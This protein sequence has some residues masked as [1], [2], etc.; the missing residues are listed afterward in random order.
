M[1][2]QEP[3]SGR[4]RLQQR[5]RRGGMSEV[6]LA[7]DEL[8]QCEVAIKLASS[9]DHDC[10]ERLQREAQMMAALTH[11]H[12][13]PAL[14]YGEYNSYYYL[15]MPYMKRGNLRERLAKGSL[16]QQEASKILTQVAS[17]LQFAHDKGIVHRDIKPSNIL[18]DD[19]DE[20]RVYLSDFGLAKK[21]GEGSD[22]TQ[23]GCLI[24]TPEYLAPELAER[25]ESV[26]SD[27]YA[28]GV[29]L[30]QMLTGRVPFTG[31]TPLSVYWKHLRERPELP[32]S[33]NPAVHKSVE[34]VILCALN[35]DPGERFA[36]AKAMVQ[37]YTMALKASEDTGKLLATQPFAPAPVTLHTVGSDILPPAVQRLIPWWQRPRHALQRGILSLTTILLLT[38]PLS[39]GFLIS[40]NSSQ[41]SLIASAST[42]FADKAL[43]GRTTTT[44]GPQNSLTI[45][46]TTAKTA[47]W[48]LDSDNKRGGHQYWSE[49]NHKHRHRC[50]QGVCNRADD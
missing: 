7:Y 38:V 25:P 42:Q 9:L 17:A 11:D 12:I 5:L 19:A 24:G 10:R 14:D 44:H 29:L 41:A 18:L 28:L 8:M 48:Q 49:G 47:I 50:A 34:Q 6:Y 3:I 39:L 26:S 13:L 16:A 33:L 31:G 40:R 45:H 35:K 22:L 32:S 21:M 30:Y 46:L 20:Q 27:I 23:T 36:S 4:Y 37:A 43:Q 1:P 2:Q 15:V